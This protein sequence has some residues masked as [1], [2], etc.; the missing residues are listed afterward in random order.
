MAEYNNGEKLFNEE[1]HGV[2]VT[3]KRMPNGE[4]RYRITHLATGLVT[5]I[6]STVE[7]GSGWQNSHKHRLGL[8]EHYC[9]Q[10]GWVLL[11]TQNL[12]EVKYQLFKKAASFSIYSHSP[13]NLY[14]SSGTVFQT[15]KF[16]STG[17]GKDFEPCPELDTY[18]AQQK[19]EDILA[20]LRR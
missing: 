2:E 1:H 3:I 5:S 7:G 17:N 16:G 18:L 6:T 20:S 8:A 11:A 9:I 4:M 12:D 13:H 15:V 19:I 14:V 10:Q